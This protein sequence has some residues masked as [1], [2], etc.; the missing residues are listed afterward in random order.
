M[1][2]HVAADLDRAPLSRP[3]GMWQE[4]LESSL[5]NTFFQLFILCVQSLSWQMIAF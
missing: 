2:W 3:G 5:W 4:Q 1:G